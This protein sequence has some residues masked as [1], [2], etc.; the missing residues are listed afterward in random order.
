MFSHLLFPVGAVSAILLAAAV[1]IASRRGFVL[2][3]IGILLSWAPDWKDGLKW[4][5]TVGVAYA[6]VLRFAGPD[7]RE[8]DPERPRS[9]K[10]GM[11]PCEVDGSRVHHTWIGELSAERIGKTWRV[12]DHETLLG[13]MKRVDELAIGLVAY[14]ARKAKETAF[15]ESALEESNGPRTTTESLGL[16]TRSHGN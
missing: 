14:A 13:A 12:E 5:A 3:L 9:E 1:G 7:A 4:I 8:L 16:E 2:V 10:Q 11:R 15:K 6:V